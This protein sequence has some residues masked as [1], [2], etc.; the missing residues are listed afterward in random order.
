VLPHEGVDLTELHRVTLIEVASGLQSQKKGAV[1]ALQLSTQG[2]LAGVLYGQRMQ[3]ELSDHGGE[4][5][6]SGL[7]ES[8]PSHPTPLAHGFVCLLQRPRLLGP[9]SVH[10]DGVV[11]DHGHIIR[12]SRR[13]KEPRKCW[14]ENGCRS[15]IELPRTPYIRA[16]Q[17]AIKANFAEFYF[18]ALR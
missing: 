12:L 11:H 16:S 6:F 8:N 9:A 10:I 5:F 2:G 15:S 3:P 18:H 7:V 1:V 4:L 14:K 17:N 13:G